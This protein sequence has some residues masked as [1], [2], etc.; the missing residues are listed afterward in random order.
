MKIAVFGST[1]KT[2]KHFVKQALNQGFE[3]KLLVR[4]INK[5]SSQIISKSEVIVGDIENLQNVIQTVEGC[6]FVVSLVGH[7]PTSGKNFQSI[8][9]K[10][11]VKAMK[12]FEVKRLISLTGAGVLFDG[13]QPGFIDKAIT[14]LL[15]IFAK[16][17]LND[18]IEHAKIIKESKLDWTVVRVPM[19]NNKVAKNNYK[20]S[21]VGDTTLDIQISRQDLAIAILDI[22]QKN[23]VYR[24]MPYIAWSK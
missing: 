8:G 5:L 7:T 4:D 1:G 9:T 20:I 10:N 19:L 6:N 24:K 23:N 22:L 14:L 16:D 12:Q 3:L 15:S 17:R 13:D 11:I 21:F 18:G 2:G